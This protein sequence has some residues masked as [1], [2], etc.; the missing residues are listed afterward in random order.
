MKQ[1]TNEKWLNLVETEHNGHR[2]LYATRNKDIEAKPKCNAVFIGAVH[3]TEKLVVTKEYRPAVKD[4]VWGVPAGIIDDD[5]DVITAAK[6]ELKEET[7]LDCTYVYGNSPNLASSAGM[8]DELCKI[9]YCSCSGE[10]SKNFLEK[11]ENIETF[12]MSKEEVDLLLTSNCIV[13][14]KAYSIFVT[15]ITIK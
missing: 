8:T 13:S 2:W 12:L 11:D 6:R 1:L 4:Y 15:W 9:V 10:L 5:E 14:A 3:N 7:G